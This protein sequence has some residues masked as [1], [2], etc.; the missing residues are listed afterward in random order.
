MP[1]FSK[2][3]A[4][5]LAQCDPRLQDV[6]NEVIK[7][8]DC[9]VLEGHRGEK[10]QNECVQKGLSRTSWPNSKHNCTPSKAADVMPYPIDWQD[11]ERIAHFAGFVVGI[12]KGK[13]INVRW[14]GDWNKD[15]ITKNEKFFDGPHF[16]LIGD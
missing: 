8:V 5:K 2:A 10:E 12:A 13:G 14:G 6:F 11:R 9:T 4:D 16:E 1:A 3:S 7:H 15:F